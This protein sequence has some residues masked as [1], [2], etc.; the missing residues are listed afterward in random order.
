MGHLGSGTSTDFAS[1]NTMSACMTSTKCAARPTGRS[2]DSSIG[3][4]LLTLRSHV[5]QKQLP[6]VLNEGKG[7]IGSG[8]DWCATIVRLKMVPVFWIVC[9][10]QCSIG[11]TGANL[12]RLRDIKG[13][14]N[15]HKL[16]YIYKRHCSTFFGPN[17]SLDEI[18]VS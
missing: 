3:G 2:D 1:P 16:P 17:I 6:R 15:Y 4:T 12:V 7:P 8:T 11:M 5:L 13:I 9:Y 10:F 18:M 14:I